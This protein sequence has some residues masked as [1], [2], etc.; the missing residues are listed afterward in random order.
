MKYIKDY[1]EYDEAIQVIAK[2]QKI[3]DLQDLYDNQSIKGV[4]EGSYGFPLAIGLISGLQ[5]SSSQ[6]WDD[7]KTIL[8][9]QDRPDRMPVHKFNLFAVIKQSIQQLDFDKGVSYRL[10]G[11]FKQVP[12]P[13]GS[14]AA[15]WNCSRQDALKLIYQ[16]RDKSLLKYVENG[17]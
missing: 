9:S 3:E 7:V 4:I 12:I 11:V 14:I 16:L 5:L 10:L 17:G 1:F 15:L 6:D 8:K 13:I 2:G